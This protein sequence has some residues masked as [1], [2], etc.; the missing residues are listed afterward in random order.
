MYEMKKKK[1]KTV[2]FGMMRGRIEFSLICLAII[3]IIFD[4]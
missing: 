1:K 3:I 4:S 2:K